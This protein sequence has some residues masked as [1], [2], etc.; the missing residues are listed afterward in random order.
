MLDASLT[1]QD[2]RKTQGVTPVYRTTVNGAD[3]D[4]SVSRLEV[5][6][7]EFQHDVVTISCTSPTITDTT[8]LIGSAISFYFG[9]SPHTELFY[10][11]VGTAKEEQSSAGA[12]LLTFT[13]ECLGTTK[14]L[15]TGSPRSWV[16]STIPQAVEGLAYRGSLGFHGHPHTLTWP[17]L[18]QTEETDWRIAGNYTKRLGWSLFNRYGVLMCYDPLKLFK[19]NGSFIDLVSSQYSSTAFE[20]YERALVDFTPVEESNVSYRQLGLKVAYFNKDNTVQSITQEGD[21]YEVF[22]YLTNVIARSPEEASIYVNA[23]RYTTTSWPQQASARVLGNANLYPGMCVNIFTS[24]PKFYRNRYNG[25]W[26]I[27]GVQHV[28]DRQTFQTQ[29]ALCRPD[30]ATGSTGMPYVPFWN[31][32]SK[33]R[34]TMML[35]DGQWL[36]SW[37]DR[38]RSVL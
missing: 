29:L 25:R 21:K 8:T 38:S 23:P 12:G 4:I 3:L 27:R 24:N 20:D 28:A 35:N 18:A 10:G 2:G 22:R 5:S 9:L 19:D 1:V 30:S 32:A 14:E 11:Y 26:L 13:L 16:N 37:T 31:Q 17:M 15:Q 34:P 36:S 6:L 33:S 7:A